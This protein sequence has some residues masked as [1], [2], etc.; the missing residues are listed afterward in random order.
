[1][2]Q[3]KA[4][5]GRHTVKPSHGAPDKIAIVMDEYKHGQL[6]SGS[7]HGPLVH[8][9]RQAIAIALSEQRHANRRSRAVR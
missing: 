9:R 5:Q 4:G 7:K 1:M 8:S 2:V 6:H 3:I